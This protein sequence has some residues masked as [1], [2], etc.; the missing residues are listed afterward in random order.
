MQSLLM[1][2]SAS[3]LWLKRAVDTAAMDDLTDIPK[4]VHWAWEVCLRGA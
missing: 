4:A 1:W 3:F 2:K